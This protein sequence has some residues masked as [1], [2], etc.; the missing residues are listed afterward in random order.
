MPR[1]KIEDLMTDLSQ[2]DYWEAANDFEE[3]TLIE[4]NDIRIIEDAEALWGCIEGC[5]K[6][7]TGY[8]DG[9]TL[10]GY[11][12]ELLRLRGQNLNYHIAELAKVYI[13]NTIPQFEGYV[14]SFPVIKITQPKPNPKQ[15]F[16]MKIYM[17][18]DSVFGRFNRVFYI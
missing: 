1:Y 16:T 17:E 9:V 4:N 14:N 6:T 2:D 5:L 7:P 12:S 3:I 13:R 10:E 15:R 8:V 11:G 18:V